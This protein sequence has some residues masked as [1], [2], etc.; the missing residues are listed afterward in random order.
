MVAQLTEY[1]KLL[2]HSSP[3]K[4]CEWRYMT[5][6]IP[7]KRAPE[8][9]DMPTSN[10]WPSAPTTVVAQCTNVPVQHFEQSFG[11]ALRLLT[12]CLCCADWCAPTSH[13]GGHGVG[14]SWSAHRCFVRWI[15]KRKLVA[16]ARARVLY[17][18]VAVCDDVSRLRTPHSCAVGHSDGRERNRD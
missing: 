14:C 8:E 18:Y 2:H 10:Y 4:L 12:F 1:S 7:R 17:L 6:T 16:R 9:A 15:F 3:S 13:L 11:A 5:C